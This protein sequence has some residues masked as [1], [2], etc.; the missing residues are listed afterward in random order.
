[1]KKSSMFL[2]TI[3]ALSSLWVLVNS[4]PAAAQDNNTI[5]IGVVIGDLKFNRTEISLDPNTEYTIIFQNLDVSTYHNLRI[6]V[7]Q[8]LE[9]DANIADSN[10]LVIGVANDAT[11]P[12]GVNTWNATWTTPADGNEVIFYCG[13]QGHYSSGMYGTFKIGNVKSPGFG[14]Y[15]GLAAITITAIAIPY[16]RRRS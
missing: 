1:M 7:N 12:S 8:N 11:P 9:T 16:L 15:S 10:D 14:L 6:D 13:F 4:T 3:L 5:V 2:V